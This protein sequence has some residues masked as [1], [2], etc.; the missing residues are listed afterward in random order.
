MFTTMKVPSLLLV[1]LS[2]LV[3]PSQ[4]ASR[5]SRGAKAE[6]RRDED[7]VLGDQE[8]SVLKA[9][10]KAKHAVKKQ[11]MLTKFNT[12]ED[13]KLDDAERIVARDARTTERFPKLDADSNDSVSISEPRR[14][15]KTSGRFG[16]MRGHRRRAVHG[17]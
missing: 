13:G 12:N 4:P 10:M 15:S 1:C 8:N 17:R 2:S 6:V 14:Q 5:R 7:G 9:D 11:E 16:G 3:L